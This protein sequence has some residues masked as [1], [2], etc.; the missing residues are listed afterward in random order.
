MCQYIGEGEGVRREGERREGE[1]E[2]GEEERGDLCGEV[3]G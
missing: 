1:R 3:R 2:R